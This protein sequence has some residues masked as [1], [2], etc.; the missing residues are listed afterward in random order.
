[1]HWIVGGQPDRAFGLRAWWRP[2]LPSAVDE[3]SPTDDGAVHF[4]DPTGMSLQDDLLAGHRAGADR[5]RRRRKGPIVLAD[6]TGHDPH[7]VLVDGGVHHARGRLYVREIAL[8]GRD[9][10]VRLRPTQSAVVGG[11]QS[12]GTAVG[13]PHPTVFGVSEADRVDREVVRG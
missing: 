8:G 6:R 7:G 2:G 10:N 4:D 12:V 11:P 5:N 3:A 1:M 9:R 13:I